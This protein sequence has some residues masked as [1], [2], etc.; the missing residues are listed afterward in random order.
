MNNFD[1]EHFFQQGFE[2]LKRYVK[3]T[4]LTV[5]KPFSSDLGHTSNMRIIFIAF[6]EM[7]FYK[8]VYIKANSKSE[9]R[10]ELNTVK[11]KYLK[12][13]KRSRHLNPEQLVLLVDSPEPYVARIARYLLKEAK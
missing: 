12:P 4:P 8:S 6:P 9:L 3:G 11:D 7:D 13:F 5:A 10:A 1:V 2:R